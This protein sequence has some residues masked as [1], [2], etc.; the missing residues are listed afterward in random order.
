MSKDDELFAIIGE[1]KKVKVKN[2]VWEISACSISELPKLQK[3][4]VEF[5]KVQTDDDIMSEDSQAFEIMAR[6]IRMGLKDKHPGINTD[7]IKKEFSLSSLPIIINIMMDLNDFL[8][9][10]KG[11]KENMLGM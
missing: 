4:M 11:L 9:G 3:L 8:S 5:E 2:K 6:I 1:T 7:I 10:M